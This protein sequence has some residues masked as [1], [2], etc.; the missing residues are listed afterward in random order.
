M[1]Q[2]SGLESAFD[3][4]AFDETVAETMLA[5]WRQPGF[6]VPNQDT[7]PHQWLWDSCFHAVI[8]CR[9][10]QDG[11][12]ADGLAR[13]AA[14]VATALSRQDPSGFV[15]HMIYWTEPEAGAEL[16]GRSG[17]ST[18]TQPPMYGHALAEILR[19][20]GSVEA[21]LVERAA[22][23]LLNLLSRPRTEAGL[24]PVFHPWET[25]CDDSA[26]WDDHRRSGPVGDPANGDGAG[27]ELAAWQACKADLVAALVIGEHG[28]AIGNTEFSVGS[29][30]FNSLV[31][32]NIRELFAADHHAGDVLPAGQRSALAAGADGV[33]DAVRSRWTG[34]R[35]AD[36]DRSFPS[37]GASESASRIRTL[38]A[39]AALLVDPRP[40]GFADLVDPEAFGAP[41][42]P[43]G[44]DRREVSYDPDTYWRGPAWPQLGYLM[45][46]AGQR[47]G[48]RDLAVEVASVLAAGVR[49][50]GLAE[51]WNPESGQGHGARPQTWTGLGL[52]AERFLA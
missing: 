49:R 25:G 22:D 6:C 36:D 5:A 11:V 15:P 18:I 8:W 31:A 47:A 38:D 24:I 10:G 40:E 29:V 23:G 4:S 7:Y 21:D 19:A 13:A 37:G 51:F 35:W 48:R 12:V 43:R 41:F 9:L 42:G 46:V 16:W 50:S 3:E 34:D 27:L 39:M 52:V 30:G 33:A 44:V 17:R 28:H 26:R 14:E 45:M 20:G 2:G 1:D 32:W